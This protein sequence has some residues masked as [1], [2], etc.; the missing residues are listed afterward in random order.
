MK[1]GFAAPFVLLGLLGLLSSPVRAGDPVPVRPAGRE[2]K[3]GREAWFWQQRSGPAARIPAAA[4]RSTEEARRLCAI[5]EPEE[6]LADWE[7]IGPAPVLH[8]TM[9]GGG[10][11]HTYGGR[12]LALALDPSQPGTLL[13]GAAQGGIWRSTD[14]GKS[15]KPVGDNLPSQAVKVIRFA[16]SDPSIVYAG[17]GEPHS[18]TSFWGMGVF[19]SLI[20]I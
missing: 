10:N 3:A 20:H 15:W 8:G 16:P 2:D 12:A 5:P 1:T 18:K 19:L 11:D 13:M 14:S 7:S 9:I 6:A 17:S 4:L